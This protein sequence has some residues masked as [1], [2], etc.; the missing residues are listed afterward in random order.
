MTVTGATDMPSRFLG[1]HQ[2]KSGTCLIGLPWGRLG[3]FLPHT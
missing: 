2:R 1:T 3:E